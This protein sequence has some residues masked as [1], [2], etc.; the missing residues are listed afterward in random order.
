MRPPASA[1]RYRR[2]MS[3]ADAINLALLVVRCSVGAVMLAHGIRHIFGGGK[4]A[5]T[6]R[7][8]ESL[9]M[10]PGR[11]H[12]WIASLSEIGGGAMLVFGLVTP[13]AAS[14]VVGTM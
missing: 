8:F 12:A 3:D 5:G 2:A 1:D 14:A 9:G 7:W 11:I 4:I 13:L 6:G 10:R